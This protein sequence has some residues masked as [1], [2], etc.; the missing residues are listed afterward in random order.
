MDVQRC[1]Y[2][3]QVVS[4]D[5]EGKGSG[6]QALAR[7]QRGLVEVEARVE[8]ELEAAGEREDTIP[9]RPLISGFSE[10]WKYDKPAVELR[11]W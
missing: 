8:E 4:P 7:E 10:N 6:R 5:V 2:H 3:Q 1:G 9:M 11:A